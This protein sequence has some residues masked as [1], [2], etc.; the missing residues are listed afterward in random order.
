MCAS[1][2]RRSSYP[3]ALGASGVT[4]WSDIWE[5]IGPEV[6]GVLRTGVATW[7]EDQA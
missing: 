1:A 2:S 4:F 6:D 7:H 3:R 5:V